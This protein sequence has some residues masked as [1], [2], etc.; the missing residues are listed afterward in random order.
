MRWRVFSFATASSM[1]LC[2]ATGGL[3]IRSCFLVDRVA[4]DCAI[5]SRNDVG[6]NFALVSSRGRI[7]IARAEVGGPAKGGVW[8]YSAPAAQEWMIT[9]GLIPPTLLPQVAGGGVSAMNLVPRLSWESNA[10]ATS[11]ATIVSLMSALPL[12]STAGLLR[13]R[14]R[15]RA[16]LCQ[17]C[18]YDLCATPDRCPECGAIPAGTPK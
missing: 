9:S 15:R 12:M 13:T 5:K 17:S 16:G 18:G 7:W 2:L 6:S 8:R 14:R 3:W 4:F 10:V 1:M 11:H